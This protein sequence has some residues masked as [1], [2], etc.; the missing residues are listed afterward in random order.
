MIVQFLCEFD[1]S[2]LLYSVKN[3][4]LGSRLEEAAGYTMQRFNTRST[5]LA[6]ASVPA[7]QKHRDIFSVCGQTCFQALTSETATDERSATTLGGHVPRKNDQESIGRVSYTHLCCFIG[8]LL[9]EGTT[10]TVAFN[11]FDNT[12]RISKD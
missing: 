8:Y 3:S 5:Q 10:G 6:F 1:F 4:I 2:R 9:I 7:S 11:S 12:I